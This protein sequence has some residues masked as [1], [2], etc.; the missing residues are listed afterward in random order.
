M[1]LIDFFI[2]QMLDNILDWTVPPHSDGFVEH[3][4]HA[5][6]SPPHSEGKKHKTQSPMW[7]HFTMVPSKVKR[8]KCNYCGTFLM[9][10]DGTSGEYIKKS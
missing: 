3:E 2:Q 10:K 4:S 1:I 7:N 8:T 9:Y 5:N 6:E